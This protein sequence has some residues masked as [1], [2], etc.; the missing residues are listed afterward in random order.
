MIRQMMDAARGQNQEQ[1]RPRRPPACSIAWH[2]A[3]NGARQ[4]KRHLPNGPHDDQG[5]CRRAVGV[6]DLAKRYRALHRQRGPTT[7]TGCPSHSKCSRLPSH[8]GS[9]LRTA[10]SKV[11]FTSCQPI[12]LGRLPTKIHLGSSAFASCGWCVRVL[13][14]TRAF[15]LGQ[16]TQRL[17]RA[18]A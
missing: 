7:V 14:K 13:S 10:F 3:H 11:S 1:K 17:T 2:E 5:G 16:R 12:S 15:V 8:F 18:C 4:T 6:G 9:R